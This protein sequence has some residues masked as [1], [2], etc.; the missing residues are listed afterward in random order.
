MMIDY[1]KLYIF[2][3]VMINE[4]QVKYYCAEP[5]DHIENYYRASTDPTQM[6]HLHHKLE[7]SLQLSR[8]ELI[9]QNLYYNR[10][11]SELIFMTPSEHHILHNIQE[12]FR[13]TMKEANNRP[14]FRAK[15]SAA[16]KEAQNRPEVKKK[17][18]Y[19]NKDRIRINN[20]VTNR[21]V[22]PNE[23][24]NYLVSGWVL[25]RLLFKK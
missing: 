11:A 7:I 16:Q 8:K 15:Q 21:Y 22:K 6:W 1:I 14:E 12:L 20:G 5:P 3:I 2:N 25:G 24:D 10:P 18:S 19:A 17:I 9:E 13:A 4:K 23:V